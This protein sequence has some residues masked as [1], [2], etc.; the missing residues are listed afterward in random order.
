MFKG[1]RLAL[2]VAFLG[3]SVC[4]V[5]AQDARPEKFKGKAIEWQTKSLVIGKLELPGKV[6]VIADDAFISSLTIEVAKSNG[7][8]V[9]ITQGFIFEGCPT[10]NTIFDIEYA[11]QQATVDGAHTIKKEKC[12]ETGECYF[13]L[14]TGSGLNYISYIKP[15][16]HLRYFTVTAG[17]ATVITDH[18]SMKATSKAFN[19]SNGQNS[20]NDDLRLIMSY[21]VKSFRPKEPDEKTK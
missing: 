4:A 17:T 15:A 1:I 20:L 8:S 19:A 13:E 16:D 21:V 10:S 9:E 14:V 5:V 7:F 11:R 12:E 6:A 18:N 2:L 3:I